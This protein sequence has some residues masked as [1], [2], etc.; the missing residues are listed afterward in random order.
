MLP[1]AQRTDVPIIIL[2]LQP[3]PQ[4][5]YQ[6]FRELNDRGAMTGVCARALSGVQ[7]SGD[8]RRLQQSPHRL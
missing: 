3:V 1:I 6:A 8:N 4:L 2:N 7:H 5:D